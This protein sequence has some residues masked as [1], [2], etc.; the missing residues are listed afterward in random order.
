MV[1]WHGKSKRKITGGKL[2]RHRNKKKFELGREQ[3][4]TKIGERRAKVLKTMGKTVKV[5]L[6]MAQ[7]ANVLT[8]N[9]KSEKV[10]IAG[11]KENPANLHYVRRNVVTKGAIIDTKIGPARVTSRPG[12]DGNINA[13]LLE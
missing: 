10:E 13:V 12:Q 11:V 2:R 1:L 5:K 6:R 7:H 3:T 9:G 8:K 4:E